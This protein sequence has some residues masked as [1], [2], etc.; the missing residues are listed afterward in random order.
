[1]EGAQKAK[2]LETLENK[3]RALEWK[4]KL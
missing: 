4:W 1:M 3:F 2:P